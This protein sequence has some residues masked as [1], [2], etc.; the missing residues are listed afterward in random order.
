MVFYEHICKFVFIACLA[1]R[2]KEGKTMCSHLKSFVRFVLLSKFL[3]LEMFLFHNF[4]FDHHNHKLFFWNWLFSGQTQ[5]GPSQDHTGGFNQGASIEVFI[6]S[7]GGIYS[8]GDEILLNATDCL[9]TNVCR[10]KRKRGKSWRLKL[11]FK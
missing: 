1:F 5:P 6:V 11:V 7:L 4:I 8:S 10:E 2:C 9:C 3:V